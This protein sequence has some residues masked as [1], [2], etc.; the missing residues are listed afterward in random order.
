M[1][2]LTPLFLFLTIAF[3]SQ[4]QEKKAEDC[5]CPKLTEWDLV[6]LCK[7]VYERKP[8]KDESEL[9]FKYQ[10]AMWRM[11]CAKDGVDNLETARKKIQCMWNK[12]RELFSCDYPGMMVP[13]GNIT[14]FSLE[15][16]FPDFLITAVK[17]YKLDMN[18]KDPQDDRTILDFVKYQIAYMKKAPVNMTLKIQEYEKL[19]K[20]LQDHG[21]KHGKDL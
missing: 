19:Y 11:S 20:M 4:A 1:K 14:K 9:A 5:D 3:S 13:K 15:A 17:D 18:F 7:D 21:A 6:T 2:K 10:E 16:S 12:N 8:A